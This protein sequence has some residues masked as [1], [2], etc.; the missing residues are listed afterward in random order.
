MEE[1]VTEEQ[2]PAPVVQAEV[3]V[4]EM[5]QGEENA[6]SPYLDFLRAALE[7]SASRQKA[8][9]AAYGKPTDVIADEI[10]ELAADLLG[11]ILLETDGIV[12]T[13]LE[14]YRD[15]AEEMVRQDGK[16]IE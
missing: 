3:V 12:Y 2:Q 5:P 8:F 16:G 13:V 10:N 4:E 6:F 9:A 1:I 14:D 7:E 15:M 11:D